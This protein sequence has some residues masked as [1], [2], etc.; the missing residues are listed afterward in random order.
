M[1]FPA[2]SAASR[3]A[4]RCGS[5]LESRRT[6]ACRYCIDF[7]SISKPAIESRPWE[8]KRAIFRSPSALTEQIRF[9]PFC[10]Q[11]HCCVHIGHQPAA[12]YSATRVVLSMA[13]PPAASVRPGILMEI[14][15]TSTRYV[16]VTYVLQLGHELLRSMKH[17]GHAKTVTQ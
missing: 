12:K 3:K 2:F 17:L 15:Q 6:R 1:G 10:N 16:P 5:N 13:A 8:D 7:Q 14:A 4:S 11:V 9:A